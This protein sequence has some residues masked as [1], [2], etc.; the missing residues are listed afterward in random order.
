MPCEAAGK[1]EQAGISVQHLAPAGPTSV[2]TITVVVLG[3]AV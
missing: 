1:A 3:I 2:A